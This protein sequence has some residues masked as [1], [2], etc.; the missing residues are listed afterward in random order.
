[1]P[2]MPG[3]TIEVDTSREATPAKHR[4]ARVPRN[5]HGATTR[6]WTFGLAATLVSVS[7]KSAASR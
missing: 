5:G 7:P 2:H 6:L 4:L 3:A 1:V